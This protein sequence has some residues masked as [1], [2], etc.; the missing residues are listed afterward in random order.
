MC[1]T[2]LAEN[3]GHKNRHLR[4]IAQL[5][6]AVFATKACIDNRKTNL[7]N[8]NIFSTCPHNMVNFGP[9]TAEIDWQV[10]GI[11]ANFNGLYVLASLLHRRHSTEVSQTL[12]DVWSS[13]GLVHSVYSFW[14]LLPPNRILPGAMHPSL[15]FSCIGSVTAQHSQWAS[16]KHCGMG[17]QRQLRNFCSS[18]A[19]PILRRAVITLCIRP[20]SSLKCRTEVS[21]S[22]FFMIWIFLLFCYSIAIG[23]SKF[24]FV[25]RCF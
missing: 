14:G 9:L 12:H 25:V 7:L 10:S 19:P 15:A 24:C 21:M 1:G 3:T 22:A 4:T 17:Q 5:C 20:H 18:F 23:T 16:A 11:P 8:S 6:Q 2:W 13:L